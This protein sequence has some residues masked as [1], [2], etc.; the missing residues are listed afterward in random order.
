MKA[1]RLTREKRMSKIKIAAMLGVCS[2]A[3]LGAA[4]AQQTD[5][6]K[7][8]TGKNV[9]FLIGSAPG[10]G[11]G[12]YGAVLGRHIGKHMPGKP[13]IVARNLDGAG[14]ITA[15][16][17]LYNKSPKDGTTFGAIFMGAVTEPLT[18]D[19]SVT[20]YDPRKF[21]YIGSANKETSICLVWHDAPVKTFD[22]ILTKEVMVGG[23]GLTSSIRQYPMVLNNVLGTKFK[24]INGYPGSREAG[25]AMERGEVNGLCGIQWTSFLAQGAEW[26][27][28]NKVR[29]I[30]QMGGFDGDDEL[31]KMKV[32]KIWDFVKNDAD[33]RTLAV[34]FNQL[35]FGRPYVLPPGVPAERVAAFRKSFDET[36]KDPEFLAEAAKAKL[37]I[38]PV[39]GAGVQKLVDEIYNTPMADVERAR[40]ALK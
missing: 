10:G 37:I 3:L 6:E 12:I 25:L 33:K 24:L 29:V 20:Q 34:I 17:L 39:N 5:V 14:S 16:N 28:N 32:P 15:A 27:A 1:E 30:A 9:D 35:E 23:A 40:A 31:N 26:M 36:M 19:A 22:E 21:I 8:Y 4:Q 38:N 7:F 13:N 2:L 11:Y 18:G